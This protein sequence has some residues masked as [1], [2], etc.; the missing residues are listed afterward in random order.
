MQSKN[1][2]R[3]RLTNKFLFLYSPAE[4]GTIGSCVALLSYYLI[5]V[6]HGIAASCL[7]FAQSPYFNMNTTSDFSCNGRTYTP[8]QQLNIVGG[9]QSSYHIAVAMLQWFNMVLYKRRAKYP[10]VS[11]FFCVRNI[12]VVL[13]TTSIPALAIYAPCIDSIIDNAPEDGLVLVV[14]TDHRAIAANV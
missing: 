1:P 6:M 8:S 5:F 10:A 9:A 12:Y 4:M 14:W 13:Y 7:P 2:I 3:E 11:S